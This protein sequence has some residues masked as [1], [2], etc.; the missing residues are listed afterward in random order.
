MQPPLSI[1]VECVKIDNMNWL[2]KGFRFFINCIGLTPLMGLGGVVISPVIC[3]PN[4]A[5]AESRKLDVPPQKFPIQDL[6]RK[7]EED[8]LKKMAERT[9]EFKKARKL[10]PEQEKMLE[11]PIGK[12]LTASEQAAEDAQLN[13]EEELDK[14]KNG[15]KIKGGK[16]PKGDATSKGGKPAPSRTFKKDIDKS[17]TEYGTSTAKPGEAEKEAIEFSGK[18]GAKK[19][20]KPSSE[21]ASGADEDAE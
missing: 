21:E 9:Q 6:I 19:K 13:K 5:L 11:K 3:V 1:L 10:K 2:F 7:V 14:S 16:S 18:P 15:V 20:A 4:S 17:P 8:R 12:K